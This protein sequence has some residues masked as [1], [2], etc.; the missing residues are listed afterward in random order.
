MLVVVYWESVY[1]TG[2][3]G[4]NIIGDGVANKASYSFTPARHFS[5]R[6]MLIAEN[7]LIN[8]GIIY[9]K[10]NMRCHLTLQKLLVRSLSK[11]DERTQSI[12]DML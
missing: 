7:F 5:N 1:T 12:R 4:I 3:K 9:F 11:V 8:I 2:I 6:Y 10:R